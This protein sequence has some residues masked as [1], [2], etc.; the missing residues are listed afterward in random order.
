VDAERIF[1]VC[2]GV[3]WRDVGQVSSEVLPMLG[4]LADEREG[5]RGLCGA[6]VDSPDLRSRCERDAVLSKLVL[7]SSEDGFRLR[8]H[9][10]HEG[11]PSRP[12]D[13]RWP[14][15]TV[16]IRG[17]Y[18][19]TLFETDPAGLPRPMFESWVGA[20]DGYVLLPGIIHD[21]TPRADSISLVLRGR[22]VR[23]AMRVFAASDRPCTLHYGDRDERTDE[24][25]RHAGMSRTDVERVL[26]DLDRT[27]F[28]QTTS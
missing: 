15:A 28:W 9:A 16:V 1:E 18:R 4:R 11:A 21:V 17:G 6:V 25:I 23:E 19:H 10:F 27:F 3:D 5:L 12:H 13:H 20:Q 14:F 22:P 8:L 24:T 7:A 2:R 26:D